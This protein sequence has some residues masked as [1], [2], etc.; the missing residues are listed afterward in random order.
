MTRRS[1][2]IALLERYETSAKELGGVSF[3]C[4][5]CFAEAGPDQ[6]SDD[7]LGL[8]DSCWVAVRPLVAAAGIDEYVENQLTLRLNED[9][10]G[11][12]REGREL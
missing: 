6:G 4:R 11:R 1:L 8:C 10:L 5:R 12:E 3:I 7:L 2:A 9:G